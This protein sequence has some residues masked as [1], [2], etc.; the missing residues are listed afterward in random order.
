VPLAPR[1][2]ERPDSDGL[3]EQHRAALGQRETLAAVTTGEL[4]LNAAIQGLSRRGGSPGG[5]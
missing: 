1:P 5:G 3:L 4:N 2:P